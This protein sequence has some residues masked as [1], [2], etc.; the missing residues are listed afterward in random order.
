MVPKVVEAVGRDGRRQEGGGTGPG[1]AAGGVGRAVPG[2]LFSSVVDH[3]AN[4]FQKHVIHRCQ[5]RHTQANHTLNNPRQYLTTTLTVKGA[6]PVDGAIQERRRP[7]RRARGL[8]LPLRDLGHDGEPGLL[9]RP[10]RL[11]LHHLGQQDLAGNQGGGEFWVLHSTRPYRVTHLLADWV[12]LTQFHLR[13][14]S[15]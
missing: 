6:R 3:N 12:I 5:E 2:T 8:L 15:E 13:I 11:R 4:P 10:P 9:G 7:G 14:T 1:S